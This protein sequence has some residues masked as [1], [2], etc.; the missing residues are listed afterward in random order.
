MKITVFPSLYDT[1]ITEQS[2][3]T[4]SWEALVKRLHKPEITPD[5]N[6]AQMFSGATFKSGGRRSNNDIL[7][8]H[9]L[10][11]D[12]DEGV[13]PVWFQQEY[14]QYEYLLY[15]SYN[16]HF[17]KKNKC[18]D[19]DVLKFR[20]CLP[21]SKPVS[22]EHFRN[23]KTV[24]IDK[25]PDADEASFCPS[26]SFFLPSAH[27]DRVK[28]FKAVH[29]QGTRFDFDKFSMEM[30]VKKTLAQFKQNRVK[31]KQSD[32]PDT[33]IE[34]A[35]MTLSQMSPE[36]EYSIWWKVGACLKNLYG[37]DGYCLTSA[38]MGPNSGIC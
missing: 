29:N 38:L 21:I 7:E 4:V 26:Q 19:K 25:F 22:A 9:M 14:G 10:V 12:Y 18:I 16:N 17:D 6:S 2:T 30:F 27:P 31:A 34:D 23:M 24:L 28:Q 3:K 8:H 37:Q 5:K 36:V 11:L 20:V 35:R 33:T 1:A 13:H 32:L 15:A